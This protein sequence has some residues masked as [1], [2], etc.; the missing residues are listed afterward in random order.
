[1]QAR[2][3]VALV[4]VIAIIALALGTTIGYSISSAK[5]TTSISTQAQ[6]ITAYVT[7]NQN[8][9]HSTHAETLTEII[10]RSVSGVVPQYVIGTCTG[11]GVAYVSMTSTSYIEPLNITGYFNATIVTISNSTYVGSISLTTI[12]TTTIT[13][14]ACPIYG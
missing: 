10:F 11:G 9:T 5:T 12:T 14:T 7:P 8:S 3:V 6:T 2:Q 4:T 13:G 1:M